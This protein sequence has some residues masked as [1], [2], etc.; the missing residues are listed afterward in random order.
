MKAAREIHYEK[1][2]LSL[3]LQCS[4]VS[5]R[6]LETQGPDLSPKAVGLRG[7][8]AEPEAEESRWTRV[9]VSTAP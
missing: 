5:H 3:I 1:R 6:D 4:T 7:G 9:G 8:Q 2:F